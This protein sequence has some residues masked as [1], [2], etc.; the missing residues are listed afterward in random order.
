MDGG[1]K[2]DS[3]LGKGTRIS[4]SLPLAAGETAQSCED[5]KRAVS[6]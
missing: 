4:F 6:A 2:L 5:G 3:A 1:F